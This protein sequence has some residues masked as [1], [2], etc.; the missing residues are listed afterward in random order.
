MSI[1]GDPRKVLGEIL[2]SAQGVD[3]ETRSKIEGLLKSDDRIGLVNVERASFVPS[4]SFER[5]AG[6]DSE[7]HAEKPNPSKSPSKSPSASVEHGGESQ[8]AKIVAAAVRGEYVYAILGL[9]LGLCS[10]FGGVAM[11][12][13]GVAGSTSWTAEVLGLKSTVNDAAPGVVLF[14]VGLFMVWVTKPR[15]N[16]K[17]IKG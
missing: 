6:K 15:V 13:H 10:I 4:G 2:R 3:E 7:I 11:G 16:L 1:P 5:Y 8:S 12:L 14:V 17:D 9:T